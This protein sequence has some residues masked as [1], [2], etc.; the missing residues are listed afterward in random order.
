[1]KMAYHYLFVSTHFLT[2]KNQL[3]SYTQVNFMVREVF[4]FFL[5]DS[6]WMS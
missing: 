5:R 3:S 6:S 4:F 1:M 2:N